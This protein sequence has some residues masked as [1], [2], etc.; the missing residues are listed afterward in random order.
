MTTEGHRLD[1]SRDI[2][3]AFGSAAERMHG[4]AFVNSALR[5]RAIDFQPWNGHWLGV[6]V[7]P[8]SIN[9]MLLPCERSEWHPVQAGAKRR[10]GFPAGDFEFIDAVDATLGEY[11]MCSL[12]SPAMEF[13]DQATAELVAK[14]A[15][16]AL[17]DA[18]LDAT[19]AAAEAG[20]DGA[21]PTRI[22]EP[23]A[24]PL[25]KRDFLRGRFLHGGDS[26]VPGR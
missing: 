7:T 14:L 25:S 5:V 17:F 3:R 2:E 15:R 10:Y 9:L 11:R 21:T 13:E 19:A 18:S 26:D 24:R 6:L 20:S 4:L 23:A 8:W 1:P 22:G 16:E 12:F